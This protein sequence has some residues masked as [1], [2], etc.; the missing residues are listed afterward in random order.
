[1]TTDAFDI[2]AGRDLTASFTSDGTTPA[3]PTAVYFE[4][5]EPDGVV[6]SYEYG[7]DA[8]LVR[9]AV[10][11]YHVTWTFAKP[12]RHAVFWRG[13]GT[14]AAAMQ[15]EYWVRWSGVA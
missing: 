13:T 7:V 12:G 4:L 10:G 3:D 14:A 6:T 5:R 2:G 1:M 11:E 8:E 15:E 9:D